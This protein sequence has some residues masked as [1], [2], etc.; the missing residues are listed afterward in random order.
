[1]GEES[2]DSKNI[3]SNIDNIDTENLARTETET[4]V[5]TVAL[6]TKGMSSL[7]PKED[8]NTDIKTKKEKKQPKEKVSLSDRID[9]FIDKIMNPEK[10]V[11]GNEPN[12]GWNWGAFCFSWIWGLGNSCYI[13][14]LIWLSLFY[15]PLILFMM[16]ICGMFGNVWAWKNGK[17]NYRDAEEFNRVQDSWNRAGKTVAVLSLIVVALML[18]FVLFALCV[19]LCV[20]VTKKYIVH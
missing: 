3:N 17:S 16:I 1:M 2:M 15:R 10:D 18:I 13:P 20:L 11:N 14:L 12:L 5:K 19:G 7:N 9:R 6:E 8:V 4:Q